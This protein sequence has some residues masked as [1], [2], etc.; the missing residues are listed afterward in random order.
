MQ[1][2]KQKSLKASSHGQLFWPRHFFPFFFSGDER[3]S[4][5]CSWVVRIFQ[6]GPLTHR[7]T[8][9]VR[10]FF[11]VFVFGFVA[12]VSSLCLVNYHDVKNI[13]FNEPSNKNCTCLI[14]CGAFLCRSSQ[15]NDPNFFF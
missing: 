9:P 8:G 10:S 2:K 14:Q 1:P 11:F 7:L 15:N 5:D 6:Y 12:F 13:R 3:Q 4:F